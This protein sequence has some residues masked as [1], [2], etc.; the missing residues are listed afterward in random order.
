MNTAPVNAAALNTPGA[1]AAPPP[2][3]PPPPPPGPDPLPAG[4]W[5]CQVLLGGVD[6]SARLTGRVEIDAEEGAARIATFTLLPAA[7]AIEPATWGGA[8]VQV[9]Y[10]SGASDWV[11]L[12]TGVVDVPEW[13]YGSR[14]ATFRCTDNRAGRLDAM[15]RAAIA[16]LVSGG[17]WSAIVTA[18]RGT[19]RYAED[20]ASSAPGAL[21]YSAAGVLRWSPWQS[22]AAPVRTLAAADVLDGSP[23]LQLAGRGQVHNQCALAFDWRYPRLKERTYLFRWDHPDNTL[24]LILEHG[25]T[26]PLITQCRQA[27]TG[28]GWTLRA[29]TVTLLPPTQLYAVP[30]GGVAQWEIDEGVRQ[31][32]A[33]SYAARMTR[34]YVQSVTEGW[35]TTVTAPQSVAALGTIARTAAYSTETRFEGAA[36]WEASSA[37]LPVLPEP[38]VQ[39]SLLVGEV[40]QDYVD[41]DDGRSAA[42][43]AYLAAVAIAST[44]ILAAHRLHRVRVS[45]LLDPALDLPQR[46]AVATD[47]LAC[48]GKIARVRHVMDGDGGSAVTECEI[49]LS[50]AQA[51]GVPT[52]VE[53]EPPTA[54]AKPAPTSAGAGALTVVGDTVLHDGGETPT[55]EPV[56]GYLGN[57]AAAFGDAGHAVTATFSVTAPEIPAADRDPLALTATRDDVRVA[58]PIDPLELAA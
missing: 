37:A 8:A 41:G 22:G 21:D 17:R 10:R 9:D 7:G 45:V 31:T 55:A 2:P 54:P 6:V 33:W 5:A 13:D 58:I 39:E 52:V 19:Y 47:R 43:A 36:D 4:Q 56:C 14:R 35:P 34:R 11:R 38:V 26:F 53:V 28:T 29:E 27:C 51:T 25:P 48:E 15:D 18:D 24:P 16:A 57:S 3:P 1:A 50:L 46:L 30:G 40:T 44:A 20:L 49:A 32:L 23:A 42:E 12:F